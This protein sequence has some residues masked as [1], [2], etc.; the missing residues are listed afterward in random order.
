MSAIATPLTLAAQAL[1]ARHRAWWQRRGTLYT[2]V[3]VAPL[4]DLWLPLAD[5][6]L[7][8]EDLDLTPNMLDLDRLAG[9]PQAAGPL[10]IEGDLFRVSAPYT[11]VPWVEAILG[12]PVRATILGGSMRT[13]AIVSNWDE[14]SRQQFPRHE[15]WLEALKQLT[16]L[17]VARSAGRSAIVQTLM[18][19][20]SDLAEA[21]LGAELLCLSLYD[22]PEA[23][24]RFLDMATQTFLD[25]LQAQ[26]ALIPSVAG[27]R[28]NAF[29]IWAPGEV[30]RT[31]CD[32]TA[33]LSAASYRDVF[34][35][36]DV[37]ICRAVDYS[38]IHLHSCSLHTTEALLATEHPHAIQVTL[39]TGANDPPFEALL[40]VF[41]RILRVKP[42]IVDGPLTP[43]QVQRL[44]DTLPSDGLCI[45][46]R[47]SPW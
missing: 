35:P 23:L 15:G 42:L 29:G 14:W 43:A 46:A 22:H 18:R 21:V 30:V 13:R 44:R 37:R 19:G 2:E 17:L 25:V 26:E 39:E 5:G 6:T 7:A 40:P 8:R 36:H 24:Q 31:Q 9:E 38:M 16:A 10:E 32:A 47:Q 34:L 45:I 28:I 33:F 20:P 1:I 3:L 27:G 11:R 4:G 12:A 41:Q